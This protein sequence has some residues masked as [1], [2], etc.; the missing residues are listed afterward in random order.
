MSVPMTD[1][2]LRAYRRTADH[3]RR[4]EAARI[5]ERRRRAHEAARL[6]AELLRGRFGATVVILFG[7]LADEEWFG[8][9]SDL[10]LAAS[11]LRADEYFGAVAALQGLLGEFEADLVDLDR[12]GPTL[13]AR[14][15]ATGRAL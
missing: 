6:A 14:V 9:R 11:G 12:C 15:L 13:R 1:E 5:A 8:P 3:R 7:S 4:E 10:D 2:Q